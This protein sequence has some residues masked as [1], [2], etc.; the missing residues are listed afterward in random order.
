MLWAE[1]A[2][3]P[4]LRIR[5]RRIACRRGTTIEESVRATWKILLRSEPNGPAGRLRLFGLSFLVFAE[6]RVSLFAGRYQFRSNRG[7]GLVGVGWLWGP[8]HDRINSVPP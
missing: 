1:A 2:V 3:A 5:R 6:V 7:Q 8:A 4:A